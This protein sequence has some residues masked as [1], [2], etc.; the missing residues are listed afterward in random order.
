ME[1]WKESFVLSTLL[2]PPGDASNK[3][4]WSFPV[5][6][7]SFELRLLPLRSTNNTLSLPHLFPSSH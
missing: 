7:T 6:M 2:S 3:G 4:A 1:M 5:P